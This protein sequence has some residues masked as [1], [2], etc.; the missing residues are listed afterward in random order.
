M[1]TE[2]SSRRSLLINAG[3]VAIGFTLLGLAIRSNRGKLAEVFERHV[4]FRLFAVA[5][6]IY[7]TALM[8]TFVRWFTLVRAVGLKFRVVDAIRL[9]FI[10]NIFNLV[11][12][13]A[14][15]GDVIKAVFLARW[16]HWCKAWERGSPIILRSIRNII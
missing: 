9:G 16:I 11:I 3:L 12:P 2:N 6:V 14:V 10:G 1:S 7:V 5:F 4:D 15:G 8:A 13:G